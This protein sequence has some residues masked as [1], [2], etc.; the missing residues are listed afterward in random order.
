M[1]ELFRFNGQEAIGL[2]VGMRAGANILTFGAELDK[3]LARA[4]KKLP[5]GIEISKVSDQPA[6]VDEA[7]G[8]FTKA[9]I[10]A[11]AIVMAVSFIAVGLRAGL[12]V[13][14]AV[15]L[16]LGITFVIMDYTGFTLQRISL[17]ALII[18]L[19]LLVDDAMIAIETM[20]TRLEVGDTRREAASY[21][22]RTIAFPMLTGTLITV[23]G[24]IPIGLNKSAA[25]E[26]TFSLFVVIAVSLLVSWIVAVLFSPLL[27]ATILPKNLAHKH[28]GPGRAQRAFEKL[29]GLGN[30]RTLDNA[31]GDH[32]SLWRCYFRGSICRTT[33]LSKL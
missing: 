23:A 8:H 28:K 27:G 18:A 29:L 2:G 7:V 20:I 10:E 31:C 9:L 21:A 11:V 1:S 6:I 15:P 32:V 17:G 22:W 25:G 14:L 16:T 24:F 19:G 13:A 33:V 3:V 5:I 12:V 30:A 26:F 4:A